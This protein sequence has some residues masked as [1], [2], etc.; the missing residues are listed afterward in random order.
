VGSPETCPVCEDFAAACR[1]P[2][3]YATPP[4]PADEASGAEAMRAEFDAWWDAHSDGYKRS[5]GKG[6]DLSGVAFDAWQAARA[7]PL[8]AAP[9]PTR[10]RVSTVGSGQEARLVVTPAAPAHDAVRPSQA[11][12][13][14]ALAGLIK[15][16]GLKEIEAALD[17]YH[18]EKAANDA[19]DAA[20][21]VYYFADD[22]QG[23]PCLFWRNPFSGE[24]ESLARFMW[25]THPKEWDVDGWWDALCRNVVAA[26][27]QRPAHD[28]VREARERVVEA[29]TAR[30]EFETGAEGV[31]FYTAADRERHRELARAENAAV[32]ALLAAERAQDAKGGE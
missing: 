25:P 10:P 21:P 12:V 18:R 24:P 28:A 17:V 6:A 8:P 2:A 30:R 13:D 4:A 20:H 22:A 32:D 15:R 19:R 27:N 31:A 9:A 5:P 3:H 11:E 1:H 29:A 7:L 14:A 16:G 23:N 26:L